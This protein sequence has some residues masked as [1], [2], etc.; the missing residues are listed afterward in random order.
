MDIRL[1]TE[2]DVEGTAEIYLTQG[3]YAIRG[4]KDAYRDSSA[5]LEN[6][7]RIREENVAG[8]RKIVK[9]ADPNRAIFVAVIDSKVVGLVDGRVMNCSVPLC[10]SSG[11][12]VGY[13]DLAHILEPYRKQGIMR[14]LESSLTTFFKDKGMQWV[15]LDYF[16]GN[17]LAA[18]TWP[19]YG[20]QTFYEMM[21]KQVSG[22]GGGRNEFEND[23]FPEN[24][25]FVIRE[26]VSEDLPQLLDL[27]EEVATITKNAD[28][29]FLKDTIRN[30]QQSRKFLMEL[31]EKHLHSPSSRIIIA[32]DGDAIIGFMVGEIVP[33]PAPRFMASCENIGSI[34]DFIHLPKYQ[35]R[36]YARK[37]EQSLGKFFVD[38]SISLIEVKVFNWNGAGKSFWI[39]QGYQAFK[40][41]GR[42][43][44]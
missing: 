41:G 44:L 32:K 38:N 42:K 27:Y 26:M 12:E 9:A 5:K 2:V 35:S 23:A 13:L 24:N 25:H 4:V 11:L 43:N 18:N 19:K 28:D 33:C 3:L 34:V 36:G 37:L 6:Q 7:E 39:G 21:R 1:I 40:R 10:I 20:Y 15:E 16:L 17:E 29:P 14:K 22:E 8:L 31:I 30:K